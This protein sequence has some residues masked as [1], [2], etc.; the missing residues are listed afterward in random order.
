MDSF[1]PCIIA[2]TRTNVLSLFDNKATLAL[3]GFTSNTL[4]TNPLSLIT[5]I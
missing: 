5:D 3:V 4:P 1:S 2:A